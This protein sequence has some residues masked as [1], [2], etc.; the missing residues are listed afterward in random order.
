MLA[1][2]VLVAP[3]VASRFPLL[4]ALGTSTKRQPAATQSTQK[5][6]MSDPK[7]DPIPRDLLEL[8]TEIVSAYLSHNSVS[9]TDVPRLLA[10]VHLALKGLSASP[11][12]AKMPARSGPAISIGRSVTPD[13][14]VC[15]EDG[16]TFRSLKRHLRVQ[17]GLT[18]Q[19]YRLKWNLPNSYPMVAPNY[20]VKRSTIAK[21]FGLGKKSPVSTPKPAR[22]RTRRPAVTP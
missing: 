15:L 7:P 20:S 5:D 14:L 9:V 2:D 17:H 18:P 21:G 8:S 22:S 6:A 13:H 4:N 3:L 12:A 10:E 1:T 11:P 19:A 16:H